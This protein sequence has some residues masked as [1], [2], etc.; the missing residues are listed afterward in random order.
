MVS[1]PIFNAVIVIIV[2]TPMRQ[3]DPSRSMPEMEH[4]CRISA[5]DGSLQSPHVSGSI[6]RDVSTRKK[7]AALTY[8]AASVAQAAPLTP[9]PKPNPKPPSPPAPPT[10]YK[11]PATLTTAARVNIR[12]GVLASCNPRHPPCADVQKSTAG[13]AKALTRR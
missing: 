13:I 10:A 6:R 1:A 3:S 11:S 5:P 7:T 8:C 4:I 2:Y 9:N 12:S